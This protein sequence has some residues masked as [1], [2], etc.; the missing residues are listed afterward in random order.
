MKPEPG[1]KEKIVASKATWEG[2]W[3]WAADDN[4]PENHSKLTVNSGTEFVFKYEN[5]THNLKGEIG[6]ADGNP[7]APLS[8]DLDLPDGNHLRFEWKSENEVEG[9]FWHKGQKNNPPATT[10]K[11]K[12]VGS[13]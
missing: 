13:K 1:L 12:R 3:S 2:N 4:L 10:S 11:M 5:Q 8:V 6:Y 7:T 9:K